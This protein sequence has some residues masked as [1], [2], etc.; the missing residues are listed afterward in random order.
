[1]ILK[2]QTR[3]MLLGGAV[4]LCGAM[5]KQD[6]QPVPSLEPCG[7]SELLELVGQP[8]SVLE[9]MLFAQQMRI[10]RPGQAVT[11]D[12][13]ETRLNIQIDENDVIQRVYCG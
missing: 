2:I 4:A 5:S 12:M 3:M 11:M 9:T 1:M 10:I 7:G 8:A 13:I 6:E